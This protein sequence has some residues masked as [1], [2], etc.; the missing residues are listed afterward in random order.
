MVP[1]PAIQA[2]KYVACPVVLVDKKTGWT[3]LGRV[4]RVNLLVM[5]TFHQRQETQTFFQRAS[6]PV[7]YQA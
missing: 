4:R 2:L 5:E 6:H 3:H 1:V 7:G